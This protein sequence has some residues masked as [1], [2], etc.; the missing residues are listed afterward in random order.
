MKSINNSVK[1]TLF[2]NGLPVNH[3]GNKKSNIY[4]ENLAKIAN[5]YAKHS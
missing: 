5:V 3:K 2:H 4:A 1:S